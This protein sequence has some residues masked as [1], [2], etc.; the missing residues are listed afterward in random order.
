[1][2]FSRSS[3]KIGVKHT[4]FG[5][6]NTA[7]FSTFQKLKD[8]IHRVV[9]EWDPPSDLNDRIN[10]LR[11][12]KEK[13]LS[14]ETKHKRNIKEGRGGLLDV[15]YLTQALQLRHGR[16]FPQLHNTKT[17]EALRELGRNSII[18]QEETKVLQKNYIFLRLIE[19]G[20]R[21]IYDDSTN[22]LDFKRVQQSTIVQLLN[23]QG[24]SVNNLREA[25]DSATIEI[26]EIYL[27]YF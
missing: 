21:L 1:M 2:W 13:E 22:L 7:R 16:F 23:Y 10:H 12:R 8:D 5:E 20:L 9:Y 25:V 6:K 18:K 14:G 3:Q 4:Y 15:E 24:Y 27:N 26:R 19:N 11:M 17:M